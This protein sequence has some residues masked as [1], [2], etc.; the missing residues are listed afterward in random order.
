MT[1][2]ADALGNISVKN[3]ILVLQNVHRDP[4]A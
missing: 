1:E 2:L 4:Y 3:A